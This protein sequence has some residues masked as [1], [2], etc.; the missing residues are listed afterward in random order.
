MLGFSLLHG[1]HQE[2][3]KSIKTTLPLNDESLMFLSLIFLKSSSGAMFPMFNP[4]KVDG[5]TCA[6][7]GPKKIKKY[8]IKNVKTLI[9]INS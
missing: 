7:K 8:R 5:V 9:Y 3:Q 6:F 4:T 1:P 2:A